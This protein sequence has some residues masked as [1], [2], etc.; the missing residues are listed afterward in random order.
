[1]GTNMHPGM[2]LSRSEGRV[3]RDL[4]YNARRAGHIDTRTA[5]TLA[6]DIIQRTVP[7]A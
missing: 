5:I 6:W 4:V 2:I 7:V 1:M 3:A